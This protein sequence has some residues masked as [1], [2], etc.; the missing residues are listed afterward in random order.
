MAFVMFI[1]ALSVPALSLPGSRIFWNAGKFSDGTKRFANEE[2]LNS[3]VQKLGYDSLAELPEELRRDLQAS[4]ENP[5]VLLEEGKS[6]LLGRPAP[7]SDYYRVSDAREEVVRLKSIQ[8]AIFW[9]RFDLGAPPTR[10]KLFASFF[11]K[12]KKDGFDE[13]MAGAYID[14]R[15]RFL[16]KK[17]GKKE[18]A[19]QFLNYILE[20]NHGSKQRKA[21]EFV[22]KRVVKE[23][24]STKGG[25]LVDVRR[26][27]FDGYGNRETL[28]LFLDQ[29]ILGR[30][31]G[32]GDVFDA[33]AGSSTGMRGEMLVK[34]WGMIGR[35]ESGG[36]KSAQ[37]Q[38]FARAIKRV[39]RN[40]LYD[41]FNQI[42]NGGE[43][44]ELVRYAGKSD[45]EFDEFVWATKRR[46]EEG[47]S[48]NDF[49]H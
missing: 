47:W 49:L 30:T 24:S 4:F 45:R 17:L 6:F 2:A 25:Y 43:D 3:I 26:L 14:K 7:P 23:V 36:R 9:L 33:I 10:R 11:N 22:S 28:E 1:F 38:K 42:K 37:K 32:G 46:I 44:G 12:C 16:A 35:L 34:L 41:N 40:Y 18:V 8:E 13:K 31:F 15:V 27:T 21:W 48:P 20:R 19:T 5:L 29:A 39:I